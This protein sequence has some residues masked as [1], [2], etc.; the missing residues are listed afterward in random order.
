MSPALPSSLNHCGLGDPQGQFRVYINKRPNFQDLALINHVQPLSRGEIH[1]IGQACGNGWR[2]VF[3]LY[4]KLIF[5]L[6]HEQFPVDRHSQAWQQYREHTLLQSGSNTALV[7]CAPLL[8][9][10][11]NVAKVQLVM[12]RSYAKS[13]TLPSSLTWLDNE[14]AVAPRERLIVCPYFDYRQL[15]NIKLLRLVT[16]IRD[17]MGPSPIKLA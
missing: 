4:A 2:K 7:F 16:L 6:E 17:I 13:L 5:A 1:A 14:F 3:N 12:G 11:Q 9:P 8:N 15:S 10:A